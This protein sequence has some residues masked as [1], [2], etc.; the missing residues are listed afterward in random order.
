[1]SKTFVMDISLTA[2]IVLSDAEV[3]I[4]ERDLD[5]AITMA[6]QLENKTV[7]AAQAAQILREHDRLRIR[8]WRQHLMT[9]DRDSLLLSGI[10]DAINKNIADGLDGFVTTHSPVKVAFKERA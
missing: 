2:K 6:A 1:M 9:A 4:I 7:T 3:E 10:K 5:D 8:A